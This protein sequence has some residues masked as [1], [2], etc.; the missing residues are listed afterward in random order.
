M[1][2]SQLRGYLINKSGCGYI[3]NLDSDSHGKSN[4]TVRNMT[5]LM[6]VYVVFGHMLHILILFTT[7]TLFCLQ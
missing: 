5:S 6:F 1:R 2:N 3:V 7:N 4:T